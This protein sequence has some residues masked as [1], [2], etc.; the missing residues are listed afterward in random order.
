MASDDSPPFGDSSAGART[1][2]G[3]RSLLSRYRSGLE[4]G[5]AVSASDD[6]EIVIDLTDERA[7][8]QE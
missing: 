5:R 3:V 1:P 6:G 8:G 2:D 7:G 4:R